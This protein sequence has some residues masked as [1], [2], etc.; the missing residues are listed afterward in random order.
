MSSGERFYLFYKDK[1]NKDGLF[2]KCK[3]CVDEK[4]PRKEKVFIT[5]DDLKECTIC[6]VFKNKENFSKRKDIKCGLHSNC[7]ECIK[8]GVDKE[9]MKKYKKQ[10]YINNKLLISLESK[11]RYEKNKEVISKKQA[12]YN[13]KESSKEKRKYAREKRILKNPLEKIKSNCRGLVNKTFR[14]IGNRKSE[15]TEKILGCTFIEFKNHIESQFLN[16]MSWENYGNVCE[17]LEYNCSWDLDHIIPISSAKTEEE[18]YLLNHWSNFQPLC[19]KVNRDEK[20]ANKPFLTN[21][22]LNITII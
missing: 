2:G 21:L 1:R 10:Y 14:D 19:S 16:W 8:N 7:K 12:I 5:E 22:E 6:K 15:K 3:K 17:T 20:R 9:G 18:V 11:I 13:K 4:T